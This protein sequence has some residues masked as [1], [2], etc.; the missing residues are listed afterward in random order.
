MSLLGGSNLRRNS[1][2]RRNHGD[3]MQQPTHLWGLCNLTELRRERS[4]GPSCGPRVSD[5]RRQLSPSG[6]FASPA[7]V[8][9][10]IDKARTSRFENPRRPQLRPYFERDR[11]RIHV[12]CQSKDLIGLVFSQRLGRRPQERWP[13]VDSRKGERSRGSAGQSAPRRNDERRLS[14]DRPTHGSPGTP[15]LQQNSPSRPAW[16]S[17]WP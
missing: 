12:D 4:C 2:H 10:P 13:E 17:F 16:R 6:F 14:I 11:E 15:R 1:Q 3:D 9:Q 8:V 5:R 7:R